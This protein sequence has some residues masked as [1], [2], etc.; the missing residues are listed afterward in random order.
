MKTNFA[1]KEPNAKSDTLIYAIIYANKLRFKFSTG[2]HINPKHWNPKAQ[3]AVK[4]NSELNERLEKF[5]TGLY[6]A[7]K[8]LESENQPLTKDSIYNEYLLTKNPAKP[9]DD[10]P[11]PPPQPK[12]SFI[13]FIELLIKES[14][15]GIRLIEGKKLSF[16]T[17]KGYTTTLN[18]LKAFEVESGTKVDF[19]TLNKDFYKEFMQYFYKH[20]HTINSLG[21]HIKN[22]KVFANEARERGYHVCGDTLLKSF[23]VLSELTDQIALSID[24]LLLIEKVTLSNKRLDKARDCFLLAC[25]TGLRFADLKK[26]SGQNVEG[27]YLRV[28]TQKTGELVIIPLHRV[29]RNILLKYGNDLPTPPSNQKLNNYIKEVAQLAELKEVI[30]V[31]KTKAG[32][33]VFRS[34]EKWEVV[35]VHTAR[36]SFATN[37][38]RTG[39][40]VISIRTMTGHKTEKSFLKYIRVSQEENATRAAQHPFF[41]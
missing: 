15:T 41:Q 25:F 17:V 19:D 18:H 24:D 34:V 23:K 27:E 6:N 39:F 11:A 13:E 36:R 28:S 30:S 32:E 9:I 20:K 26:L 21:K 12:Q 40:D 22:V 7:F 8:K 4:G 2:E 1:L 16:Y 5:G 37:L 38:Y 3:A 29:V 10:T 14:E 31:G 35:T 33:K